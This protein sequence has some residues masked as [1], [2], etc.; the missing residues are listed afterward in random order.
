MTEEVIRANPE[1]RKKALVL[2]MVFLGLGVVFVMLA[3]NYIS[4]LR[5]LAQQDSLEAAKKMR[6]IMLAIISIVGIPIFI[7]A[8]WLSRFC[9]RIYKHQCFPPPGTQVI[10][11]TK[12]VRASKARTLA[13][14]G[15][16]I[17]GL[18]CIAA[19][20]LMVCMWLVFEYLMPR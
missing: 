19:I 3:D 2:F 6:T 1:A 13:I 10:K 8:F 20:S 11:D 5:Q 4:I 7:F 14:F 9:Q 18:L 16:I 17:S 15:F 12:I